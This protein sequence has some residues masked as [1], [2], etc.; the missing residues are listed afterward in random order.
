V[1]V[2]WQLGRKGAWY[3]ACMFLSQKLLYIV[4]VQQID[5][6]D[7]LCFTAVQE[8]IIIASEE[9]VNNVDDGYMD[10]TSL[11]RQSL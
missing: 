9:I 11:V 3:L 5:L 6:C 4:I 7:Q 1:E 2:F 8:D 10:D